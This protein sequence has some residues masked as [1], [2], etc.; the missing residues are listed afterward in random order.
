MLV[1]QNNYATL[2]TNVF[3]FFTQKKGPS[4]GPLISLVHSGRSVCG[5]ASV[6]GSDVGGILLRDPSRC[7]GSVLNGRAVSTKGRCS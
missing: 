2:N 1:Q 3:Y 5:L 6:T 4:W 7:N